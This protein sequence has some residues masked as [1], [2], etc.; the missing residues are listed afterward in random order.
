MYCIYVIT[1]IV[2]FLFLAGVDWDSDAAV[3]LATKIDKTNGIQ[4]QGLY[5]HCGN[6]YEMGAEPDFIREVGS[7]TT[8]CLMDLA[9]K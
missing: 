8:E 2:H 9:K 7:K 6:S 4:F 3:E 5:T 1:F